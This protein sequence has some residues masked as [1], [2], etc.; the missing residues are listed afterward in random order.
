M[1]LADKIAQIKIESLELQMVNHYS[2]VRAQKELIII[3]L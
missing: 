1:S 3:M 2:N